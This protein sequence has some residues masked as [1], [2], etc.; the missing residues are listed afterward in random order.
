[1][2]SAPVIVSGSRLDAWLD[3]AE[4][5]FQQRIE[6]GIDRELIAAS[7]K[8]SLE[9]QHFHADTMEGVRR[10]SRRMA[11]GT[12]LSAGQVERAQAMYEDGLRYVKPGQPWHALQHKAIRE[13]LEECQRLRDV[14]P[15]W[16]KR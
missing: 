4:A 6:A 9:S 13:G 14:A 11:A 8:T 10:L 2:N 7:L 5:A 12:L 3:Q 15:L 16:R 1:M